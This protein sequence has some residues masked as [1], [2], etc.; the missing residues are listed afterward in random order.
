M[1]PVRLHSMATQEVRDGIAFYNDRRPGLGD[2]FADAVEAAVAFIGRQPKAK[3]VYKQNY[4]K[5]VLSEFPYL[6]F[7]RELD[8]HVWVSAVHH[9]S[10]APDQWMDRQPEDD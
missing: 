5:F 1:K 6:I 4:R 7:Y 9:A 10:R 2:E 3:P 8:D